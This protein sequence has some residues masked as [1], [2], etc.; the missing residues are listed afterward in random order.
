LVCPKASKTDIGSQREAVLAIPIAI[1]CLALTVAPIR[2]VVNRDGDIS[3]A[4]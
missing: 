1:F 2:P 3:L 4:F